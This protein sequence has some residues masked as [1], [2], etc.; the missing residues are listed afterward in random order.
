MLQCIRCGEEWP[1]EFDADFGATAE[2]DGYGPVARC[3]NIVPDTRRPQI[4]GA[5]PGQVC[6]GLLRPASDSDSVKGELRQ[7][8][9]VDRKPIQTAD[10]RGRA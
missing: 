4:G 3:T 1:D 9:S 7:L 2:G 10:R 6:G 8:H 5:H